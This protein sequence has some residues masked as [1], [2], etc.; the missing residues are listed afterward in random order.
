M[1]ACD[2]C[3]ARMRVIAQVRE[4]AIV[5]KILRHLGLRDAPLPVSPSRGPTEQQLA[6]C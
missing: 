3:G 5:K 4:G 6:L 1:L 2:R